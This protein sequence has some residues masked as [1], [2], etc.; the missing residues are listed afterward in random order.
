MKKPPKPSRPLAANKSP[1]AATR[2]AQAR[3]LERGRAKAQLLLAYL[4]RLPHVADGAG[5]TA[6]K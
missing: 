1:L 6:D 2:A 5:G 3:R 4:G